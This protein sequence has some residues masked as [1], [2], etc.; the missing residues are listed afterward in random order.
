MIA[1]TIAAIVAFAVLL[2]LVA[3]IAILGSGEAWPLAVVYGVFVV[4][5]VALCVR[6]I[7]LLL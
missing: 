3:A 4:V 5:A 6:V 1:I 2:I 7:A